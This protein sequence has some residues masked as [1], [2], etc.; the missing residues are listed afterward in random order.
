MFKTKENIT[1][2]PPRELLTMFGGSLS[3]E[4]YRE[5]CKNNNKEYRIYNPPM[6]STM[7]QI[8]EQTIYKADDIKKSFIPVDKSQISRAN[9]NLKLK[10]NKP[11]LN[12]KN[13][14][15]NIMGLKTI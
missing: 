5:K 13:T 15:E 11:L 1:L 4:K 6:I 10:R 14:L 8:E 2:A 7:F 3:I 9:T 12:E